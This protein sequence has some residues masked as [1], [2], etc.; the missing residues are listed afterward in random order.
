[1]CASFYSITIIKSDAP[2]RW[3][4][5]PISKRRNDDHEVDTPHFN[6]P[7][8]SNILKPKKLPEGTMDKQAKSGKPSSGGEKKKKLRKMT[9]EEKAA[10]AARKASK[11]K[12]Y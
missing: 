7:I 9:P 4:F 3:S 2:S 11:T 6:C 5:R 10:R 8:M 12:E 1:M